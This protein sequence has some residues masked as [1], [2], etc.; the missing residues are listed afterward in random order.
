MDLLPIQPLLVLNYSLI[1]SLTDRAT[2]AFIRMDIVELPVAMSIGT[3][4]LWSVLQS[5]PTFL[6]SLQQILVIELLAS[7]L[8]TVLGAVDVDCRFRLKWV[9]T[10]L[11]VSGFQYPRLISLVHFV[12]T[13]IS[14]VLLVICSNRHLLLAKFAL[15]H[16]NSITSSW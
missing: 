7:D 2:E 10:D 11:T 15:L 12:S 3:G 13:R 5:L 14:T 4:L 16:D 9:F 1:P 8:L 6:P